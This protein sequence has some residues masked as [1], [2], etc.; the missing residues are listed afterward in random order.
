MTAGHAPARDPRDWRTEHAL[1]QATIDA[2]RELAR[3]TA[4]IAPPS[5]GSREIP[6][7]LL[8]VLFVLAAFVIATFAPPAHAAMDCQAAGDFIIQTYDR[9]TFWTNCGYWIEAT[10]PYTPPIDLPLPP[11]VDPHT[12]AVPEPASWMLF[13]AGGIVL[14]IAR[15]RLRAGGRA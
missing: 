7:W 11:V 15:R 6:R 8:A 14:V 12:P 9:Q 1:M 4:R 2:R 10:P 3:A 13:A 5:T